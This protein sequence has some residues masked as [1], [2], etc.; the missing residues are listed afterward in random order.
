MAYQTIILDISSPPVTVITL[1]RPDSA[2]ALNTRM[3]QDIKAVF[4][5]I[6]DVRAIV[7]AGTGK[8]FCAGADLKE[9]QGLNDAAWL[10]QHQLFRE[11][12]DAILS[13]P[14]PVIAAV[15]GAAYAGGLEL[16]LCCDFIY[17]A[18]DAR[19]ALTEA[20]LGI[21][22]GMGG[23]QTLP[24]RIG[25]NRAREIVYTGKPFTAQEAYGW[26]MVNRLCAADALLKEAMEC[27]ELIAANAPL[28]V[29]AIKKAMSQGI[30]QPLGDALATELTHYNSLLTTHD[31]NEGVTAWGEKRKANFTGT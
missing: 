21:M 6:G 27:G 15:Q 30:D 2:N 22:P 4:E 28:S 3:A 17:A 7:L 19:F 14:V 25:L 23:T 26:G 12:R 10:T 20:T 31:K 16:A 29:Q 1:N 8:H 5:E 18:N 24:R 11:A 13:C 9:R